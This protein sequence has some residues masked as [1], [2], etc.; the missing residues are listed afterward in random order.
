MNGRFL[1]LAL[2]AALAAC[3]THSGSS[4]HFLVAPDP[5]ATHP[6]TLPMRDAVVTNEHFVAS[7]KNDPPTQTACF[8]VA[9]LA[10]DP[11]RW[12]EQ[13]TAIA[14]SAGAFTLPAG[15]HVRVQASEALPELVITDDGTWGYTSPPMVH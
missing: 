10:N 6:A 12:D 5:A 11:A 1:A 14:K 13:V 3:A 15:T 8:T 7:A 9:A 4:P 2:A